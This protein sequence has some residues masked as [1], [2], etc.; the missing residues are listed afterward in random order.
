MEMG[1]P[2]RRRR[3]TWVPNTVTVT[4]CVSAA[5]KAILDDFK[6]NT[7]QDVLPFDYIDPF[8]QSAATYVFDGDIT[9]AYNAGEFDS[10]NASFNLES[11]P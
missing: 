7:V 6:R 11:R 2:K 8:T 9:Y 4:L 3:F 5:E 10:W 1:A